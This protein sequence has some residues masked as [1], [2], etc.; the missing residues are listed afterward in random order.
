MSYMCTYYSVAILALK[1]VSQAGLSRRSL[2][3]MDSRQFEEVQRQEQQFIWILE[4]VNRQR[5]ERQEVQ[6]Q[7]QLQQQM[8][9]ME[10]RL[11]MVGREQLIQRTVQETQWG[12][13][14]HIWAWMTGAPTPQAAPPSPV[15][16]D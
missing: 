2:K 8:Q 5:Q 16:V 7:M 10:R 3:M 1:Q 4:M 11:A 15:D 12:Y 9:T 13:L 6:Q 14:E